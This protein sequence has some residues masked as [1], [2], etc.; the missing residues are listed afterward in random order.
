MARTTSPKNFNG[1]WHTQK[2][3]T[4]SIRVRSCA[5]IVVIGD[6]KPDVTRTAEAVAEL[7]NEIEAD[8][9]VTTGDNARE[10]ESYATDVGT[11]YPL[12]IYPT[13]GN[14]DVRAA[15]LD[16]YTSYFKWLP[17][18]GLTANRQ[19]WQRPVSDCVR[20]FGLNSTGVTES[21]LVSGT[22]AAWLRAQSELATEPWQFCFFHNPP[23]TNSAGYSPDTD[24]QWGHGPG[25]PFEY[26]TAVFC[27]HVHHYERLL[28]GAKTYINNGAGAGTLY[29]FA[30]SVNSMAQLKENGL[31][32]IEATWGQ[33]IIRFVNLD[34]LVRDELTITR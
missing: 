34:G 12:A 13:P 30:T 6:M 2:G 18:N 25:D 21:K 31:V 11:Y 27:G 17:T 4:S 20:L 3:A 10:S 28:I 26:M 1:L 24:M 9:I 15:S 19:T 5:R 14:H 23:Y 22:Q 16:A 32:I 29:D 33:C 8:V 7:V